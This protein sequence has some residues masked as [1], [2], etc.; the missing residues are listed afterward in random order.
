MIFH[1]GV[2]GGVHVQQLQRRVDNRGWLIE[3]HRND[4]QSHDVAMQYASLTHPGVA[5]GPH[6]HRE[7][8]DLFAFVGPGTFCLQ[9]WDLR[10]AS[11]T[12][13]TLQTLFVGEA[14]RASVL[15]PPGVAHG[16]RNI[17]D[18]PGLVINMPDRLYAGHGRES[19][20]DEIRHEARLHVATSDMRRSWGTTE[21]S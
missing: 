14:N 7:Q 16:Y 8:T 6:E 19:P 15:V 5:R 12:Y 13:E 20:V 21:S 11:P 2:I 4:E 10:K 9:L 1:A 17:S 3:L 18:C